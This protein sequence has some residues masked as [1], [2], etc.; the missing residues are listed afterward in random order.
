M[1]IYGNRYSI[2]CEKLG[3]LDLINVAFK[4]VMEPQYPVVIYFGP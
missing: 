1:E 4:C 3:K 2:E